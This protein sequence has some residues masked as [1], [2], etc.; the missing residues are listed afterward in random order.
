MLVSCLLD[1]RRNGL[2]ELNGKH[3]ADELCAQKCGVRVCVC[4]HTSE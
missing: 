1:D 4:V 3:V 2:L